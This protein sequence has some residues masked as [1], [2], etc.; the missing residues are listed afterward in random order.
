MALASNQ[1]YH[2]VS[3]YSLT[4]Q[5]VSNPLAREAISKLVTQM[6]IAKACA[7]AEDA[8]LQPKGTI[9]EP[10][11]TFMQGDI[12]KLGANQRNS[13]RPWLVSSSGRMP[14]S[15]SYAN[16]ASVGSLL[17]PYDKARD[18]F[19]G[20]I[21][22]V[23]GELNPARYARHPGGVY[24]NCG[25]LVIERSFLDQSVDID[26][27]SFYFELI[28]KMWQDK[29]I[30]EAVH[31]F[32]NQQFDGI[33]IANNRE[34]LISASVIVGQNMRKPSKRSVND[35]DQHFFAL[36][37]AIISD[38]V[39]EIGFQEESISNGKL[40]RSIQAINNLPK[41][42]KL[43]SIML[44]T[45][46]QKKMLRVK[47]LEVLPREIKMQLLNYPRGETEGDIYALLER[48]Q[49]FRS[50]MLKN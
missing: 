4:M 17:T 47:N 27:Q 33:A 48:I 28:S 8:V 36:T 21:N 43:P 13:I 35:I 3:G 30:T 40:N 23:F 39:K 24:P 15:S 42:L 34:P 46:N 41:Q 29:R 49:K 50:D 11:K 45:I 22:I 10:S 38:I 26:I 6:F 14:F 7:I 5:K 16:Q 19:S 44:Y 32:A 25:T 18:F 20:D 2:A 9:K 1:V 37:Q 12:K 31:Y